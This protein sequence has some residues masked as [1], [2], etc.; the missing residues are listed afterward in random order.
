MITG[1]QLL[2]V[3]AAYNPQIWPMQ[4]VAYLLG[5]A[6]VYLAVRKTAFSARGIPAILA[7]FWLW[8]ALLFWLPSVLQGFTPGYFFIAIFMIQ[9]L[10]FVM[11][12]I[13]PR[14]H[15]GFQPGLTTWMGLGILLY[16]LVGYP[17]VGALVG[18]TYPRMSPFGLTPCPVVTFTFGLLLLTDQKVP[19]G[20]LILPF[21][22]ALTGFVW[23]SIGMWE[24]IGMILSG[25]VGTGSIWY[26]DSRMPAEVQVEPMRTSAN[27]GWS[28]DIP[29]KKPSIKNEP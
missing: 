2:E 12:A 28:L 21:L 13:K 3:F 9:G 20:L 6:A 19:K 23:I 14:L 10:F 4:F 25:L 24:D 18:H 5:V 11:Y 1:E 16:A 22:Y 7:F 27:G 26:R 15:F 8:V 17:L 29:D